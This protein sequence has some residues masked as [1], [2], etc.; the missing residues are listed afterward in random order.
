MSC[1]RR[2]QRSIRVLINKIRVRKG[3]F[4]DECVGSVSAD[5]SVVCRWCVDQ[6]IGRRV[7]WRVGVIGFFTFTEKECNASCILKIIAQTSETRTK[8]KKKTMKKRKKR[9]TTKKNR[10]KKRNIATNWSKRTSKMRKGTPRRS[11]MPLPLN[12]SVKS[13]S[14]AVSSNS[15]LKLLVFIVLYEITWFYQLSW[16]CKLATVKRLES[17]RFE[18]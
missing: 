14:N 1:S 13:P 7:Y 16:Q 3:K 15:G 12:F 11:F 6:R 5:V 2:Q 9:K 18:R 17:W 8:R 4:L 10:R